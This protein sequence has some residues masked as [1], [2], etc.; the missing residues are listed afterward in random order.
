[1]PRLSCTSCGFTISLTR[2]EAEFGMICPE[3]HGPRLR[4]PIKERP[5]KRLSTFRPAT[6]RALIGGAVCLFAGPPVLWQ[7]VLNLHGKAGYLWARAVALG[8]LLLVAAVA[9]LIAG[10]IGVYRDLK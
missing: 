4:P 3:C 2:R 7:G 8:V 9:F 6:V 5:G 10:L 1:M